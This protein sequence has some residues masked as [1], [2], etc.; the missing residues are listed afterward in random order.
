MQSPHKSEVF[1]G[2]SEGSP[3]EDAHPFFVGTGTLNGT[4]LTREF[5]SKKTLLADSCAEVGVDAMYQKMLEQARRMS[6]GQET[7][8]EVEDNVQH[9][10]A[11]LRGKHRNDEVSVQSTCFP[12]MGTGYSIRVS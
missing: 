6:A 11:L 3:A 9:A 2:L 10:H 4:G 1:S 12:K 5:P 7:K 8:A